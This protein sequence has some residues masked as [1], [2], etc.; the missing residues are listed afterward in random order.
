MKHYSSPQV[1][2]F[3]EQGRETNSGQDFVDLLTKGISLNLDSDTLLKVLT[4]TPFSKEM[5]V[6]P[7]SINEILNIIKSNK[8][9]TP[10]E[11][12]ELITSYF[13]LYNR[14][15]KVITRNRDYD[16]EL[17]S[18][19]IE[20]QC[21]FNSCWTFASVAKLEH[22]FSKKLGSSVDLSEDFFYGRYILNEVRAHYRSNFLPF[23]DLFHQRG[24]ASKFEALVPHFGIIPKSAFTA[25]KQFSSVD[26][27]AFLKEI[28]ERLLVHTQAMSKTKDSNAQLNLIESTDNDIKGII[29]KY[30][31]DL[32]K[33]F[34]H[35]GVTYNSKSYY[36]HVMGEDNRDIKRFIRDKPEE[37]NKYMAQQEAHA[38]HSSSG[39]VDQSI[40]EAQNAAI[41]DKDIE[42]LIIFTLNNNEPLF[43]AFNSPGEEV[44]KGLDLVKLIDIK[45]G[46]ASLDDGLGNVIDDIEGSNAHAVLITGFELDL[47]GKIKT[48]KVRNSYG[49]TYGDNGVIHMDASF[50]WRYFM[51]ITKS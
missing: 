45:T 27:E 50:F 42:D 34:V 46:R 17:S 12:T 22:T 14:G 1:T 25:K 49:N 39:A 48:I 16:Q 21:N 51:W 7:Q 33:E 43:F 28:K 23:G 13:K 6:T 11:V 30:I 4:N 19:N 9:S 31:D 15:V 36:Q 32:D 20:N 8:I 3:I 18:F 2:A 24:D 29:S 37:K 10:Q 5:G 47:N 26:Q 38:V 41:S 40:V 44:L 35:E